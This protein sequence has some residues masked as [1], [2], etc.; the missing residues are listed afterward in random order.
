MSRRSRNWPEEEEEPDMGLETAIGYLVALSVPLWLVLEAFMSWEQSPR[1]QEKP[2]EAGY[3][4]TSPATD[5]APAA[6]AKAATAQQSR[7]AA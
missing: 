5:A 4:G 2:A 6:R 7:M 3:P 1:E